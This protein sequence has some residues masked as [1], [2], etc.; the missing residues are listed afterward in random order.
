MCPRGE[1]GDSTGG[2]LSVMLEWV[3]RLPASA[4]IEAVATE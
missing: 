4:L 2:V 1:N 3:E